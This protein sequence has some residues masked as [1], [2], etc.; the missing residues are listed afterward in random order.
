M[1]NTH[2]YIEH[3]HGVLVSFFPSYSCFCVFLPSSAHFSGKYD[4]L[5]N[6]TNV[7]CVDRHA[8][9]EFSNQTD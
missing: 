6:S 9:S 4:P 8:K 3:F 1:S 2:P 7:I 5:D